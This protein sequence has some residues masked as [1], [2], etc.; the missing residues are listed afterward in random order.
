MPVELTPQTD[1]SYFPGE[2]PRLAALLDDFLDS[3]S[4]D[5]KRQ[6]FAPEVC[7]LLLAGGYGRG[8]GGVFRESETAEPQLYNDLEFYLLVRDGASTKPVEQWCAGQSHRGDELLGIEVEFK[9]LRVGAFRRADYSMFFYDLLAAHRL[10]YGSADFAA[11]L[12]AELLDPAL[13]P[14]HEATRLLFNRGTGLFFSFVALRRNDA[15]VGNGFIERNHA[16]VKL[17]LADAVLASL[18]RYHFSCRERGRRLQAGDLGMS[19]PP[20][21]ERLKQW[22]A[23]GV[24]FK[25]Y[26]RHRNPSKE[27]LLEDH[28]E[29]KRVW[30]R[31]FLW[32]ETL[33]LGAPFSSASDY[34][35]YY[36]R[37]FP[38]TSPLLN[39]A[40]HW[41]DRIKRSAALPAQFDYPRAPLQR[42]LVLLLEPKPDLK[43]AGR[44]LGSKPIESLD[45][46]HDSYER[47]WRYYN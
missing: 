21:W 23:E 16:K 11:T 37:L 18:G 29:L 44:W 9:V 17:A 41:R 2:H 22:H 8:E 38:L 36:G 30:M 13:I 35:G 14:L 28:S 40:I 46:L 27:E 5:L 26:P 47:W 39:I 42:A 32:L 43:G 12:R 1:G 3:L 7:V 10:V 24:E 15:R 25:M 45:L 31:T 20:D 34:A 4:A 19:L 33:R 6:P